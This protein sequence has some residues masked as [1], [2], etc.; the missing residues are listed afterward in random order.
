MTVSLTRSQF[1]EALRVYLKR[2][3]RR[4]LPRGWCQEAFDFVIDLS[5]AGYGNLFTQHE[6]RCLVSGDGKKHFTL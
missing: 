4:A 1:S 6:R 2:F 5:R 3:T